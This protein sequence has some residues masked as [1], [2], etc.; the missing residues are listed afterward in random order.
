MVHTCKLHVV[1]C[2][3]SPEKMV[4]LGEKTESFCFS[5]FSPSKEAFCEKKKVWHFMC[6]NAWCFHT[7]PYLCR[8]S[9]IVVFSCAYT[10][11]LF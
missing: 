2:H 5:H 7:V 6:C 4:R 10:T 11:S 1:S 3:F 8:A 9:C